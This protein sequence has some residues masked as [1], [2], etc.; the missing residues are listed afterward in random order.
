MPGWYVVQETRQEE[1]AATA[2]VDYKM[3]PP[4]GGDHN[5]AWTNRDGDV[6]GKKV[7]DTNAV[8]SLGRGA[9][10]VTYSDKAA[11]DDVSAHACH[12][13]GIRRHL[14]STLRKAFGL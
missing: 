14:V 10:W 6:C 3:S 4:V 11:D 2:P 12:P 7:G 8:R 13:A 9:V 1:A 5:P